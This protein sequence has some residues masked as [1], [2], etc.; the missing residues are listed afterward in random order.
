MATLNLGISKATRANRAPFRTGSALAKQKAYERQA[1]RKRI[2]LEEMTVFTQQLAAMLDAG[3]PLVSALEALEEQ[4]GNPVFQVIIRKV[5]TE[6]A[7]G[8]SFSEACAA[9]PNAFPKL[10]VSMVEAGEAS[11]GLAEI[12]EKT[13]VY[14]E[15]TVKLLRQVKAALMYP[16]AVIALAI[17]LVNVLLIFVIPVFSEM[18][19]D[20]GSELP[21]P[22]QILIGIS[23]FLRTYILL[24][25]VGFL[26]LLWLL[27]RAAR[28]PRGR[29]LKDR[30]ILKIPVLGELTRK[31]N[32]SR[33]CRTYAIPYAL[34][35]AHPAH[36]GNCRR[37]LQ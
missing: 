5:R 12:L 31:V 20:F 29:I 16:I 14:F 7:A 17:I 3:L 22:T 21:T 11:G 8:R 32:L 19:S 13:S 15:D 9:Y 26:G 30:L 24:L 10:F 37:S 2:K 36:A 23:E 27:R 25:L 6:V 35:G 33:F 28:T 1:K 18:F 4:A 34:W